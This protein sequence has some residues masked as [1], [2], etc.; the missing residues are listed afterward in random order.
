MPIK[1]FQFAMKTLSFIATY[2]TLTLTGILS[3]QSWNVEPGWLKLPKGQP[4]LGSMHGDIAVSSA[5]EIYVS[6]SIPK[7]G[8]QVYNDSGNWLRNIENAPTDLH[9]FVIRKQGNEEFIYGARLGANQVVKLDLNGKEILSIPNTAIPEQFKR[10]DKNGK[11]YTRLTG[12]D[13]DKS[14][15]I[16]VTDGY[17]SDY[18]HKFNSKGKYKT[19]F[20]GKS[21]PYKFRTLHKLIIDSRFNPARVLGLDRAN[22]RIV[23]L[24]LAGNFIGVVAEGLKLP[25]G[26]HIHK[27][28]LLVGELKGSV[29]VLNK[30]GEIVATVGVNSNPAQAGKNGVHP[31][32]WKNGVV[33]AP[34]GISSNQNGDIFVA[35]WNAHGRVHRFNLKN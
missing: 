32:D 22:N 15:D 31:S 19:T 25:A 26:A 29:S 28:W 3:A 10:K 16:Y 13:V 35:E 34:H 6:L 12:V 9:G 30:K 18:I 2:L 7:A 33:T 11:L 24:S 1:Q 27:D 4:K 20:G 5:N 23:H 17:S 8:L 14:G 21:A